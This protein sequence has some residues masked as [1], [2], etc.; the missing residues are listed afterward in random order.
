L[1]DSGKKSILSQARLYP[2]NVLQ[3]ESQIEHFWLTRNLK[4]NESVNKKLMSH[5]SLI[6]EDKLSDKD[7][8]A[9]MERFKNI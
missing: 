4:K 1:N 3:N 2:T 6:Q 8:N 9:I 5:D 7:V